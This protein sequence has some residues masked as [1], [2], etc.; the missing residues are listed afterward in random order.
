MTGIDPFRPL[1]P[2]SPPATFTSLGSIHFAS[3]VSSFRR[4]V[5]DRGVLERLSFMSLASR[6]TRAGRTGASMRWAAPI[7]I[8]QSR[9]RSATSSTISMSIIRWWERT[10]CASKS[11]GTRF[12]AACSFRRRGMIIPAIASCSFLC[13][14]EARRRSSAKIRRVHPFCGIYHQLPHILRTE[15]RIPKNRLT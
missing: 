13:A 2:K 1:E 10:W 3:V 8:I 6:W 15:K 5:S 4:I 7:S 11:R 12:Q 9:M 14:R